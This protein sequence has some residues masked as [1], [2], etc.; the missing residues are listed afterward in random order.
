MR[1]SKVGL[2]VVL[3]GF[4]GAHWIFFGVVGVRLGGETVV[5]AVI[6]SSI[7]TTAYAGDNGR[8]DPSWIVVGVQRL[9]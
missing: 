1:I 6:G 7:L 8:W 9:C 5:M 3:L 2:S 4:V